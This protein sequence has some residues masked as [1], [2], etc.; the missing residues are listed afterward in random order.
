[1]N[2]LLIVLLLVYYGIKSSF[3]CKNNGYGKV[4][5]SLSLCNSAYF[6]TQNRHYYLATNPWKWRKIEVGANWL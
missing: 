3:F 1:M 2:Y 4:V 6:T 5:I